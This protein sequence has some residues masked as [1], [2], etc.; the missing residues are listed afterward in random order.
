MIDQVSPTALAD[1]FA[2]HPGTPLMI[3]VREPHEVAMLSVKPQGVECVFMPMGTIPD[4]LAELDPK[5]PTALLCAAG[6]RSQRVAL[7]LQ[8]Q[9]F[10]TLANISGGVSAWPA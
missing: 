9:G 10:D 7:F 8:A 5:R 1:W 2:Q 4:R 6:M 3:D